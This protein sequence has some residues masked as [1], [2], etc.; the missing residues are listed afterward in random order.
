MKKRFTSL[1]AMAALLLMLA[2]FS[3]D[4]DYP[5]GDVD[6]TGEVNVG[7]VATLIDYLL[8]GRWSDEP[9]VPSTGTTF[10]V[11]GVSFTMIDVEGGTFMM[12][13]TDEQGNDY[14]QNADMRTAMPVHEV[15][16][17]SFRIGQTEVTQALWEAV[18]GYNLSQFT[19][20]PQ[21]PVERVNWNRCQ[22][23]IAR[24]NELT[25]KTFRMLTEAEWEFAARGGIHSKGYKYAGSD[26]CYDVAW[27]YKNAA[28]MTHSVGL[29]RP[30]ELGLYDMSGNVAE[31]VNDV[32]GP[33]SSEP[34]TN[35]TGPEPTGTNPRRVVRGGHFHMLNP[36]IFGDARVAYRNE[37]C[38]QS[39]SDDYI[40]LRL[41]MDADQ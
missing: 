9:E 28:D 29:K 8:Y 10:T 16:L 4:I 25:G 30:N 22:D 36:S 12:G 27:V 38:V 14:Y 19:G 39:V 34:Q 41:A 11:N 32:Y 5:R 3:P 26:N 33:Y 1:C 23:F 18:M 15:T 2:S 13:A 17:S 7:D 21:R 20:N 6:K 31:W 37:P 40:G 24:L 35:P